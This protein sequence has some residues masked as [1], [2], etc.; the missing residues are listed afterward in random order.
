MDIFPKNE[1]VEIPVSE[2][3][4]LYNSSVSLFND[5]LDIAREERLLGK[6]ESA[7][8]LISAQNTIKSEKSP[9]QK[10]ILLN[11]FI[12]KAF[13]PVREAISRRPAANATET[14]IQASTKI[15][16]R[17][18]MLY[19]HVK[20]I[21]KSE[22]RKKDFAFGSP[23]V[24]TFLAGKEGQ[25]PSRRDAIRAMEKAERL[26]PALRCE[27][28]PN[29]GR[30]TMRLVAK[31]DDLDCCDIIEKDCERSKWQRFRMT[32]VLPFMNPNTS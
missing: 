18:M 32:E 24:R 23:D 20:T 16:L 25:A 6:K 26:F 5:I 11:V 10:L 12:Q 14:I 29:D 9:I 2:L 3:Q 7:Q 27:H 19:E 21:A 4:A 13:K 8:L 22:N 1:T 17:A 30:A 28:T 31:I 15:K